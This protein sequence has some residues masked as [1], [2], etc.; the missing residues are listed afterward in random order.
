MCDPGS[1]SSDPDSGSSTTSDQALL[2]LKLSN[3]AEPGLWVF[4]MDG[5]SVVSGGIPSIHAV[6]IEFSSSF[7][8]SLSPSPSLASFLSLS[9]NVS[10]Q[11][12]VVKPEG[13]ARK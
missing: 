7:S 1:G 2:L 3:V 8:P 9:L 4:R 5:S 10:T 12:K 11:M 6:Q 13:I